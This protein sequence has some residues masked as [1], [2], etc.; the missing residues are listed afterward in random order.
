[1]AL[2]PEDRTWLSTEMA[3]TTLAAIQEH[4]RMFHLNGGG[5]GKASKWFALVTSIVTIASLVLG[6]LVWLITH[7]K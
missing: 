7:A 2:S 5:I 1:M 3:N 6:G 4:E